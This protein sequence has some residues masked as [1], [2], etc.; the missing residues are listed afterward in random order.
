MSLFAYLPFASILEYRVRVEPRLRISLEFYEFKTAL[1]SGNKRAIAVVFLR[2]SMEI[3]GDRSRRLQ[4]PRPP[5][6]P[7]PAPSRISQRVRHS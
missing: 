5:S 1:D 4:T 7:D 2:I 3:E 6:A